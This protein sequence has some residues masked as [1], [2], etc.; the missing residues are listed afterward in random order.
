MSG[1]VLNPLTKE[2]IDSFIARP[3]HALLLVGPTGSG[4]HTLAGMIT[5]T[6][7]GLPSGGF[8]EHPYVL[9]VTPEDGKAIGI[10]AARQLEK[11]LT[12][13]VP[14][15]AGI[16]RIIV[17]EDAHLLTIEAQNALLKTLEEP[18][19]G[20]VLIL[21][22]AH[23]R[24][25]LPTIRSRTQIISIGR[26]ER[27][28]LESHFEDRG[29]DTAAVKK[30]Y[31]MSGGLPGLMSALLEEADHP[32]VAATDTARELLSRTAY[33]RLA[34]VD[35]LSKQKALAL[36]ITLILQQMARL[37]LQRAAGPVA[38]RWRQIMIASH[39]ASEALLGN[40][41]PKLVLTKLM[42]EL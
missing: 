41:Q 38:R 6:I 15:K 32:L 40:A 29:H 23:E 17:I 5:E 7:L 9:V 13:K 14:G 19:E 37:S 2:R 21:A 28:R 42:L 31:A 18:P 33:E 26:L 27:E 39:E 10:E 16:N 12:L 25:L 22:A 30:A 11:F 8:G 1:P 36:D 24:A 34:M 20:T 4:K 3:S 35:E